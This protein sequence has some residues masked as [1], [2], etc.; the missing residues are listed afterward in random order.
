MFESRSAVTP[1][2]ACST[3]CST[4]RALPAS[5]SGARRLP[6]PKGIRERGLLAPAA[7]SEGVRRVRV[8][9]RAL[10][11]IA[12]LKPAARPKH[13]AAGSSAGKQ[14]GKPCA[15]F[16][17]CTFSTKGKRHM[18]F[19]DHCRACDQDF[20]SVKAFDMHRVGTH[21][22]SYSEGLQMTPPR[23]DGRR[24]LSE[25]EIAN[26]PRSRT[27]PRPLFV[28]NKRGKWSLAGDLEKAREK[29]AA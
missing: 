14:G 28:P 21:E 2:R 1:G 13:R 12:R 5:R 6:P 17:Y 18:A 9:R 3:S 23:E 29:W 27:D 24:C 15:I 26:T 4:G 11:S 10:R 8:P 22:Y 25:R 20:G 19:T 7:L 16:D